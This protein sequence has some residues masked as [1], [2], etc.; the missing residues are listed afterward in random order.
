M[1][2]GE[3]I[4]AIR[5]S[6]FFHRNNCEVFKYQKKWGWGG[7]GEEEIIQKYNKKENFRAKDTDICP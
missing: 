5:I 2:I 1:K 7:E 4:L 6:I 3:K